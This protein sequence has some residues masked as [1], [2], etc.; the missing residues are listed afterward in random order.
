MRGTPSAETA[1]IG[2]GP[3]GLSI[4]AHL[5]AQ[6]REVRIFGRPMGTWREQMPEGMLL[7]SEAFAS[8]LSDAAGE[9]SLPAFAN[10]HGVA[11][12]DTGLPIALGDYSDYGLWF[13]R[14]AVPTVETTDVVSLSRHNGAF[15]V[16]LA[17]G[18]SFTA[19]R[20][21][22]AIGTTYFAYIP[23]ELRQL[24][25]KITHTSDHRDLSGFRGKNVTVVGA[26][27]SA[28]ET[29]ALLHE[30]DA[31]VRVL[32]RGG[33]LDW[34][35]DPKPEN[36]TLFERL[37]CPPAELCGCG[38]RCI[39]HSHGAGLFHHLPLRTRLHVVGS[40]FGPAG[41]W[42][43]R[44]RVQGRFEIQMQSRI[45]DARSVDGQVVLTVNGA[46]RGARELVT[47]H[48]IAGT[49]YQVDISAIPFLD[50]SVLAGINQSRGLPVLSR[51]FESTVPGLYFVG[52]CAA[53]EFGPAMR[54]VHG[55]D[56]TARRLAG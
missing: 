40:T 53:H 17:T 32:V 55:A 28:L 27:Q 38:W 29:A 37:R 52:L 10:Q 41:A 2:A 3:Y 5:L 46:T 20:V 18:E 16:G 7:K 35:P 9:Y 1:I 39:F 6:R 4:A 25:G 22:L 12:R 56:F 42:W 8:S 51:T 26:G 34:N 23:P 49:G 31:N 13:Q 36:R 43:L 30:Q 54:F 47:D 45:R 14:H 15:L 21:V 24:D 50:R 48:V 44:P 19:R 11:Y 33:F